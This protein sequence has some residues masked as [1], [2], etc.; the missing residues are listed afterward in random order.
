MEA[1]NIL[2]NYLRQ[3]SSL[4]IDDTRTICSYFQFKEL[5]KEDILF[6][7][8]S[9]FTKIVFVAQGILRSYIHDENGE[10]IIKHFITENDFFTEIESFDKEIPCAFNVAAVTNCKLLTLSKTDSEL[11]CAK[12]PKW[13]YFI[14]NEAILAMNSMIRKQEFLSK[15]EAIDKYRFFIQN[16][17][18]LAQQIPLKYIAS[19]LHIN[20]STLSRIRKQ[21]W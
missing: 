1:T 19:Y 7:K 18:Q 16:Y 17:P 12:I 3:N 5:L 21:A 4:S 2:N 6:K 8:G 10:E 20:Q 11:L 15:G 9:R 14:K 13:E